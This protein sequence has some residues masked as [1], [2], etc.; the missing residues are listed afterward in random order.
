VPL[1]HW[2]RGGGD[3]DGNGPFAFSL[4]P[5]MEQNAFR[6]ELIFLLLC[7]KEAARDRLHSHCQFRPLSIALCCLKH[8]DRFCRD[9]FDV[10]LHAFRGR[11]DC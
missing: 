2:L 10:L 3:G 1:E 4:T 8:C 6:P 7:H 9:Y 11:A 5:P